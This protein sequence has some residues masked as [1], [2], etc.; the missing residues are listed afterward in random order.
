VILSKNSQGELLAI[1][2]R[3]SAKERDEFC[4]TLRILF[5]RAGF[6]EINSDKSPRRK[7]PNGHIGEH[8]RRK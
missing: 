5:R 2:R 8:H 3:L 1:L 6:R 7:R 4:E